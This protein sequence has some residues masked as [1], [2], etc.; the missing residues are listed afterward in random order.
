MPPS[1]PACGNG[2]LLVVTGVRGFSGVT[3][4]YEWLMVATDVTVGYALLLVVTI[5]NGGLRVYGVLQVVTVCY[6]WLRLVTVSNGW[7]SLFTGGYSGNEWLLGLQG[8][9][10]F[11]GGYRWLRVVTN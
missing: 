5:G 3:S 7:L 6:G 1:H 9:R 8:L 2:W 4:G 10:V 11:T